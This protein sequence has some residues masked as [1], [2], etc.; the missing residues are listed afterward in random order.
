[1]DNETKL[2]EYHPTI[3]TFTGYLK[4][5]EKDLDILFRWASQNSIPTR[6]HYMRQVLKNKSRKKTKYQGYAQ[7]N[8]MK[9]GK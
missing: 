5:V 7:V 1:M 6:G 2:L 9:F 8:W 4:D 3:K